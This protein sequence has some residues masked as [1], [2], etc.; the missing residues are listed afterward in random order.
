MNVDLG[1]FVGAVTFAEFARY[2]AESPSA[3]IPFHRNWYPQHLACNP[4][5]MKY[6]FIGHFENM[7]EDGMRVITKLSR[8]TETLSNVTVPILNVYHYSL[9]ASERRTQIYSQVPHDIVRKL[10]Q[11]YKLD[12]ELFGYDYHWACNS[13]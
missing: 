9:K 2:V 1:I 13:C 6:D 8:P 12:Y 10:I 5:Y 3:N 4:C 7:N 11:I